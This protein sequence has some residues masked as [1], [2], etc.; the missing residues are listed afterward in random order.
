[1]GVFPLVNFLG[2]VG[3]ARLHAHGRGAKLLPAHPRRHHF[4]VGGRVRLGRQ[5]HVF[6][7][8]EKTTTDPHT[9]APPLP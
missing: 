2:R 3:R 1:M 7:R 4:V 6:G 8:G 5:L 9:H